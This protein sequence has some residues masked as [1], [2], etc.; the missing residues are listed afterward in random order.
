MNIPKKQ[1]VTLFLQPILDSFSKSYYN[2]ITL[3][4]KPNGPLALYTRHL[5]FP[6]LSE[7][8]ENNFRNQCLIVLL[9]TMLSHSQSHFS[10]SH[11]QSH[12]SNAYSSHS[13][14][15]KYLGIDDISDVFSFLVSNGYVIEEELTHITSQFNDS[16]RVI[17]VFSY[18]E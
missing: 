12:S 4:D 16:R 14:S 17:C 2:V 13:H 7:F 8:Q 9:K 11:S 6:K 15:C 5:S 18:T 10:H 1:I 3:S